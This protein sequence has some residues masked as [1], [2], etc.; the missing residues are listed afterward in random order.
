MPCFA[1]ANVEVIA[2][3]VDV[4]QGQ[5]TNFTS[6]QTIRHQQQEDRVVA[7]A[8]RTSP[9]YLLQHLFHFDPGN[10]ARQVRQ[11]ISAG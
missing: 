4:V 9:V 11:T 3:P 10:R 7:F 5:R 8:N 2:F 1:S 6:P